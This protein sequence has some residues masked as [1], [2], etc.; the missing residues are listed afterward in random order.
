[1]GQN[2]DIIILEWSLPNPLS[3][4]LS[5]VIYKLFELIQFVIIVSNFYLNNIF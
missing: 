5:Q 2:I 1:M 4:L 3:L